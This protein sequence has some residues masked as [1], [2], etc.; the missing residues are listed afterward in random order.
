MWV[1]VGDLYGLALPH[2]L[3]ALLQPPRQVLPLEVYLHESLREER[4]GD[5]EVSGGGEQRPQGGIFFR[6][7]PLGQV[8]NPSQTARLVGFNLIRSLVLN[9]RDQ[10]PGAVHLSQHLYPR[11][12]YWNQLLP[13]LLLRR[14]VPAK[15]LADAALLGLHP[16]PHPPQP[17]PHPQPLL[18]PRPHTS[19]RRHSPGLRRN[20]PLCFNHL[21]RLVRQP[22][23]AAILITNP[24]RV[25]V[26]HLLVRHSHVLVLRL[27]AQ[28]PC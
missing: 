28:L 20:Q 17:H 11:G 10:V 26:P 3:P 16:H 4:R 9:H 25:R 18:Q 19:L 6:A 13:L 12:Q 2:H 22:A 14:P 5:F 15:P 21:P 8:Y 24:L 1:A 23:R 27:L 7:L